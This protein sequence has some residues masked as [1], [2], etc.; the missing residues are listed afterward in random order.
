MA[1]YQVSSFIDGVWTFYDPTTETVARADA[2]NQNGSIHA[3]LETNGYSI[4]R[5]QV[6]MDHPDG[7]VAVVEVNPA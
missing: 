1:D 6:V 3:S 7:R 5:L 2:I 4:R